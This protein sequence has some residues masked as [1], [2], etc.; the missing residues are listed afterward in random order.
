MD[1]LAREFEWKLKAVTSMTRGQVKDEN[2][3]ELMTVPQF[4]PF[5]ASQ[6]AKS[7]MIRMRNLNV[8]E[9]SSI[10]ETLPDINVDKKKST[11]K[12]TVS[13]HPTTHSTSTRQTPTLQN[14]TKKTKPTI[15][16]NRSRQTTHP[17][18]SHDLSTHQTK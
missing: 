3:S 16:K 18:S 2:G 17:H 9:K 8:S 6:Q 10:I 15:K 12:K 14:D 1:K 5:E 11:I 4:V 7:L 13:T